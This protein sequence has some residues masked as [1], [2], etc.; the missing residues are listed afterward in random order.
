MK[1][2]TQGDL[3]RKLLK[4]GALSAAV[5]GMTDAAGQI[6][7]TDIADV[8]LTPGGT[9]F[10]NLDIDANSVADFQISN[11]AY[12]AFL[13]PLNSAGTAVA[14]P[15]G[16]VGFTATFAYPSNLAA[17]VTVDSNNNLIGTGGTLYYGTA[18]AYSSAWC[19]GVTDGYLG[20]V[21]DIGGASHYG[22]A[23]V[24]LAVDRTSLVIKDYAYNSV[25]GEPIL[26]GQQTLGVDDFLFNDFSYFVDT[27]KNLNLNSS[28]MMEG[29]KIYDLTGKEVKEV[30][31]NSNSAS[32]SVSNLSTGIYLGKTTAQG[33]T[34]SFKFVLN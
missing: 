9:E 25:A 20:L 27:S 34:K 19:G 16:F 5:M 33:Q 18:C 31:L 23:R 28:A 7:Y 2:T 14:G 12:G 8:T 11:N 15:N 6:V 21:I 30:K 29:I 13:S 24:D 3:S 26:T 10:V 32:L 4:Y 17:D 22:W 1:K